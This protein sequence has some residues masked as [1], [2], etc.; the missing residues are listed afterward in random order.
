MLL[1]AVLGW[2][3]WRNKKSRIPEEVTEAGTRR[4]YREE[5][6]ARREGRDGDE[7]A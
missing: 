1:L 4:V 5:E 6:Q 2:A 7:N 3:I